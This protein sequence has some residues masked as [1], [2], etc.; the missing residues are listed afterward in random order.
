MESSHTVLLGAFDQFRMLEQ[1]DAGLVGQIQA[2]EIRITFLE[3][4]DDAE[5]L[6]V[7]IEAAVIGHQF[8]KL[9]FTGMTERSV[10]QIMRKRDRLDQVLIQP[11]HFG[12]DARNLT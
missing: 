9:V 4:V 8:P 2:P 5:A 3:I 10:P 11:K 1:A 7:V 6:K 12:Y